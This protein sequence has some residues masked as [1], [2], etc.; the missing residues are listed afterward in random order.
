MKQM[1][2]AAPAAA[3]EAPASRTLR[4]ESAVSKKEPE[5]RDSAKSEEAASDLVPEPEAWIQRMLAMKN[6]NDESLAAELAAFRAAY[7][8]YPLPPALEK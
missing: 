4:A 2:A 5:F 3:R 1:D 8:D 6:R 7:P